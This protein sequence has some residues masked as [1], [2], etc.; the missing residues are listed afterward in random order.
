MLGPHVAGFKHLDSKHGHAILDRETL[1]T[2][3]PNLRHLR[4]LRR[5]TSTC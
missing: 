2:T 1:D 5:M 4:K 3:I